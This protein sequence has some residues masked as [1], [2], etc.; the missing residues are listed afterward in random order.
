MEDQYKDRELLISERESLRDR[1]SRLEALNASRREVEKE[2]L[3]TEKLYRAVVESVADGIAVTMRTERVFVNQAFLAIHGLRD[4]SEVVGHPID[5]FV[6]P[7]DRQAIRE[8]VLARQRGESLDKLVEYR[9]QRPDGEIRTVQA[10]VVTISYKGQPAVL[11]VIRDITAIK[12]AEVEIMRLNEEFA[13]KVLDLRNAN[14]ELKAFNSTVSHDLRTP[15]TVI[16]GFAGRITKKY[17]R[18]LDGTFMDQMGI[19]QES[20]LKMEQLIDH[21]L[22]YSKLGKQALQKAPVPMDGLVQSVVEE[23]RTIYPEGEVTISPLAPCTGDEAMLRQVFANLL[24][25]AFKFSSHRAARM[26]E[27]GCV[28]H[29]GENVYFVKDNG[30]GFDMRQK[31]KLFSVFQRLHSEE[32]FSGNGMGLAIVKRIVSLHGGTVWAEGTPGRGAAFYVALPK[33]PEASQ[34]V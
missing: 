29:T 1:I 22:S 11:A 31:D 20:A 30:A 26:I 2:L 8:R 18:E 10:S 12:D 23:L 33:A 5:Q 16:R 4:A 21:L 32:E 7:E 9:I 6:F 27:V 19:I 34:L 24:S 13:Q 28:E 15:L 3:E 17:G 25:N 14:D